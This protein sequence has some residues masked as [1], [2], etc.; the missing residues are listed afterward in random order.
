MHDTCV[1]SKHLNSLKQKIVPFTGATWQK[2]KSAAKARSSLLKSSKYESIC[3]NLPG[4]FSN[5]HGYH[6][7][8]YSNFTAVPKFR[9]LKM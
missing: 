4:L 5:E 7:L 3:R 2:V 1:D 8:C 6:Q 9:Y